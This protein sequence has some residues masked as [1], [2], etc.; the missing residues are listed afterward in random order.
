MCTESNPL[1]KT[2]SKE[3]LLWEGAKDTRKYVIKSRN[4]YINF[5]WLTRVCEGAKKVQKAK[6]VSLIPWLIMSLSEVVNLVKGI[7]LS[8][9]DIVASSSTSYK[10]IA[11]LICNSIVWT[12]DQ[13][14]NLLRVWPEEHLL[15]VIHSRRK[16]FKGILKLFSTPNQLQLLAINCTQTLS[17]VLCFHQHSAGQPLGYKKRLAV[18]KNRTQSETAIWLSSCWSQAFLFNTEYSFVKKPSTKKVVSRVQSKLNLRKSV[19]G[20]SI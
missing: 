20:E 2:S 8:F 1:I 11:S 19:S 9:N 16:S 5:I 4:Y 13:S 3:E 17:D 10:F 7:R 12:I 14:F 18:S 6:K 15:S